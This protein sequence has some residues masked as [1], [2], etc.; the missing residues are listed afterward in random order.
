VIHELFLIFL[1]HRKKLT[2]KSG[3]VKD[4]IN[5]TFFF[6]NFISFIDQPKPILN[7]TLYSPLARR[8]SEILRLQQPVLQPVMQPLKP[9]KPM[10]K[11]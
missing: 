6:F 4:I 11:S 5:F 10:P 8:S 1:H 7:Q 3:E 2:K 9:L